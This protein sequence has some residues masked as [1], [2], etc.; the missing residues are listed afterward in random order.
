MT[1]AFGRLESKA[2]RDA[3]PDEAKDFTPWLADT[4]NLDLLSDAIGIPLESEGTEVSVEQFKADILARNTDDGSTVLIENQL[5]S[6]NHRHLG[7]ILT[8]LA[9]LNTQT[10]IWIAK[11]FEEPHLSAVRWLNKNT[12]DSFAFFAV[13]VKVVQI[14]D[15]PLAPL[16]EVLEKPS[17]WDRQLRAVVEKETETEKLNRSFWQHYADRHPDDEI[18]RDYKKTVR[19]HK[20]ESAKLSIRQSL[21]LKR[22]EIGILMRGGT[23]ESKAVFIERARPYEIALKN[24][25]GVGPDEEWVEIDEKKGW[26]AHKSLSINVSDQANWDAATDWLHEHLHIYRRILAQSP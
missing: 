19:W 26:V 13:Q 18:R 22:G 20:V 11:H 1:T 6:S 24:E 4:D 3:W 7:Q 8:Y 15:S 10:V 21:R 5:E 17:A 25:V 23:A 9:G 14:G 16:F 2:L 12:A